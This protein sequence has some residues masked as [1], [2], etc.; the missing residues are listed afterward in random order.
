[1]MSLLNPHDFVL[2]WLCG[3][4]TVLVTFEIWRALKP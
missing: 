1:M 2:G 4:L 3:V